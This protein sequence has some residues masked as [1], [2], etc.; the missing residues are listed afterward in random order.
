[1]NLTN[2]RAASSSHGWFARS[3][4]ESTPFARISKSSCAI[5]DASDVLLGP[6]S[7]TRRNSVQGQYLACFWLGWPNSPTA[8][9]DL[10]RVRCCFCGAHRISRP[11]AVLADA[12]CPRQHR[13]R[14][15]Q[16]AQSDAVSRYSWESTPF[17]QISK[18]SCATPDT[19]GVLSGPW[20][21]LETSYK[22]SSQYSACF[23]LG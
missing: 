20:G 5:L 10:V 9:R 22:V 3:P 13:L 19:S 8:R 17:A 18:W 11:L 7:K 1:M 6:G 2:R 14:C 23:R 4:S 15:T 16:V 12:R 21:C